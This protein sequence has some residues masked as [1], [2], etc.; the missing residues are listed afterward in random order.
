[1]APV[2]TE[3][4][5][6]ALDGFPLDS[7]C[8]SL[9]YAVHLFGGAV[10]SQRPADGFCDQSGRAHATRGLYVVDAS[11]LP[12]NTGVNPQITVSANA[13]WWVALELMS[14]RIQLDVSSST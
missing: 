9:L 10:M 14:I 4:D 6:G 3:A 12:G 8:F 5:L 11:C 13:R 1:M 7:R 2:R